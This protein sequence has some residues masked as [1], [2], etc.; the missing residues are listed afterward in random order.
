LVT[1]YLRN[2]LSISIKIVMG[3]DIYHK[4]FLFAIISCGNYVK[5]N[6]WEEILNTVADIEENSLYIF[7]GFE[8]KSLIE[9]N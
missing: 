7:K 9:K 8:V 1:R 5:E 6:M 3:I 2:S 4:Y